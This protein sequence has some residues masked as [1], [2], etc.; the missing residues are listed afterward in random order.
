MLAAMIVKLRE[1]SR[2]M[3][4]I[5]FNFGRDKGWQ[6]RKFRTFREVLHI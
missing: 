2:D 4:A 6:D 1:L 3:K 5:P